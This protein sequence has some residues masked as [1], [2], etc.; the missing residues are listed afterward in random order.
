MYLKYHSTFRSQYIWTA[1]FDKRTSVQTSSA[2]QRCQPHWTQHMTLSRLTYVNTRR[3]NIYE[4]I[5]EPARPILTARL[6]LFFIP[7]G[8]DSC[9]HSIHPWNCTNI[10]ATLR[11]NFKTESV[12]EFVF[13]VSFWTI[14]KNFTVIW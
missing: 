10:R 6:W 5:G 3:I 1:L 7:H 4:P 8:S 12:F 13:D 14:L 9:W 11:T 2:R